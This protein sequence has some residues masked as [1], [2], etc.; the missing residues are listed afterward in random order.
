MTKTE[1][2]VCKNTNLTKRSPKRNLNRGPSPTTL[3]WSYFWINRNSAKTL[4][5]LP[6]KNRIGVTVSVWSAFAVSVCVFNATSKMPPKKL[7]RLEKGQTTLFGSASSEG[8]HRKAPR[9]REHS[10]LLGWSPSLKTSCWLSSCAKLGQWKL[11]MPGRQQG[12]GLFWLQ[13]ANL[14]PTTPSPPPP[15]PPPP[16]LASPN[17]SNPHSP[18]HSLCLPVPNSISPSTFTTPYFSSLN[19]LPSSS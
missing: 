12:P 15:S 7:P 5:G 1:R 16:L 3:I 14:S 8:A 13:T 17:P 18:T 2:V 4:R 10:E 11:L 9:H 19:L 6:G